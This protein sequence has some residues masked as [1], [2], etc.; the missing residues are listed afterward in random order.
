MSA[1]FD[2]RDELR[3]RIEDRCRALESGSCFTLTHGELRA[4]T[5]YD[6]VRDLVHSTGCSFY[7]GT[8]NY[9]VFK[10]QH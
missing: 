1:H 8:E 3:Q 10:P 9:I 5:G 7:V 6:T 2:L 4:A